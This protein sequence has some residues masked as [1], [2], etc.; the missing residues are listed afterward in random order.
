MPFGWIRFFARKKKLSVNFRSKIG[1]SWSE[2]KNKFRELFSRYFYS[3][4]RKEIKKWKYFFSANETFLVVLVKLNII[5]TDE[6]SRNYFFLPHSSFK[7]HWN[8][9]EKKY[10]R[11]L[12]WL[13]GI[14]DIFF[15]H[16]VFMVVLSKLLRCQGQ[17]PPNP[18][19]TLTTFCNKT[20]NC[21]WM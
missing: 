3:L 11:F 12:N 13:K 9:F 10:Q 18:L 17:P 7:H 15:L 16:H 21:W 19:N 20:V 5:G 6:K 2:K 4:A 8:I 14:K 1:N